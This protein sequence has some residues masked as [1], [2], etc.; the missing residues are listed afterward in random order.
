MKYNTLSLDSLFSTWVFIWTILYY[1]TNSIPW[2]PAA[3]LVLALSY[4]IFSLCVAI[5][6]QPRHLFKVILTI[7]SIAFLFKALPLYL[8]WT[9]NISWP[10]SI[11]AGIVL[12]CIYY[13][14]IVY[15]KLSLID[16]YDTLTE[17]LI[18]DQ[19]PQRIKLI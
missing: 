1:T 13:A 17:I 10:N 18:L 4:Q 7:L 15:K 12:F 6:I 9:P 11:L 3:S 2:N 8:I 5:I 14:Y 19:I 16:I